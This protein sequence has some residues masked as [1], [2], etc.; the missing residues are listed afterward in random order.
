MLF[1]KTDPMSVVQ[2]ALDA[3]HWKYQRVDSE[4]IVTGVNTP[5][6]SRF[7]LVFRHETDKQ[8]VVL[9][10][11]EVGDPT[12]MLQ[13]I[14]QGN[15]PV[16]QVHVNR[17]HTEQQIAG[18]CQILLHQNYRMVLGAFERDAR[19]GEIRFSI[20]L[21][22]RNSSLT[23]EQV[24]WSLEIAVSSFEIGVSKV[25]GF[26]AGSLSLNQALESGADPVMV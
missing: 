17:G 24:N 12:A 5:L 26:L 16:L 8:T 6:G 15:L 4:T 10:V 22:Y 23:Q 19:D 14:S 11:N 1:G 2:Q 25:K 21:P 9:L 20:A 7:L 13:A 18:V 3:R